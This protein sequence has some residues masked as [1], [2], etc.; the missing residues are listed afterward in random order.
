LQKTVLLL[1]VNGEHLDA[2][3]T[4]NVRTSKTGLP[5]LQQRR[6]QRLAGAAETLPQERNG[7]GN[8]SKGWLR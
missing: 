4:V 8:G 6:I 1:L 5:E 3:Y 2:A 7:P